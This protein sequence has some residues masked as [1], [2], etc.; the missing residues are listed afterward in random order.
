MRS[1]SF[2][3]TGWGSKRAANH[4]STRSKVIEINRKTAPRVYKT[5]LRV[6]ITAM[7]HSI[8][9]NTSGGRPYTSRVVSPL[10]IY[11]F[12]GI[13]INSSQ[14]VIKSQIIAVLKNQY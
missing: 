2:A 8:P 3:I 5:G 13:I 6:H 4:P 12:P 7:A 1:A 10:G 14:E 11:C 9:L